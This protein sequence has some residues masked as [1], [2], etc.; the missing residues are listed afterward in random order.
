MPLRRHNVHVKISI[1]ISYSLNCNNANDYYSFYTVSYIECTGWEYNFSVL[2]PFGLHDSL[3]ILGTPYIDEG[4]CI[5]NILGFLI[6]VTLTHKYLPLITNMI[7]GP[8]LTPTIW[9]WSF[10]S[11]SEFRWADIRLNT[12][13][14]INE[15]L[16]VWHYILS[17]P[18]CWSQLI[19]IFVNYLHDNILF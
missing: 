16:K 8:Q 6:T 19:F 1:Y 7:L 12:L 5:Y 10:V 17:S 13:H 9:K 3:C 2:L 18:W 4:S 11:G 14:K 15:I